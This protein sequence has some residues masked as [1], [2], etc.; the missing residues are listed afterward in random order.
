MARHL[1][2]ERPVGQGGAGSDGR[3]GTDSVRWV[4]AHSTVAEVEAHYTVGTLPWTYKAVQYRITRYSR[5]GHLA[6]IKVG[7]E[8][9]ATHEP[10]EVPWEIEPYEQEEGEAANA[11]HGDEENE[12]VHGFDLDDWIDPDAAA[13]KHGV[14][15]ADVTR[16]GDGDDQNM[17][18]RV[19]TQRR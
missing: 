17:V 2:H 11:Y 15:D 6:E 14:L 13:L 9:E 3:D 8:D 16:H 10:G 1:A 18:N 4:P 12:V 7:H 5:R 19:C